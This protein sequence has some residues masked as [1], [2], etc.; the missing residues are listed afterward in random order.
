M[1]PFLLDS[2]LLLIKPRNQCNHKTIVVV[3][4]DRSVAY[5]QLHL[6]NHSAALVSYNTKYPPIIVAENMIILGRVIKI[7]RNLVE[8]WQPLN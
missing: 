4:I 6:Y 2:A 7:E 1:A 8:G 5:K 3:Y